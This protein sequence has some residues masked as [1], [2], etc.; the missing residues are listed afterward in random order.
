MEE[1]KQASRKKPVQKADQPMQAF[2]V[3]GEGAD[4][5]IA[6]RCAKDIPEWADKSDRVKAD[7]VRLMRLF[8]ELPPT[9]LLEV[10]QDCEGNTKIGP[11]EGACVTLAVLRT[12][13]TFASNSQDFTNEKLEEIWRYLERSKGRIPTTQEMMSALA[14]VRGANPDDTVQSSLAL[15]MYATHSAAMRA[16]SRME[17]AEYVD[18]VKLF[19]T[20]GTKLLNA[21]TR[22]AETL[23][24]LQRGGEQVIKHIHIDNRGGQ[25]VVTD[26]LIAG[27]QKPNV[28]GQPHGTGSP[29]QCPALPGPDAEGDVVPIPVDQGQEAV[30]AAWG[31]VAGRA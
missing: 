9:P 5:E 25:A 15:Q 18:Q 21:Y 29:A 30:Q 12:V 11:E 13:E 20:L 14:F 26:Q 16:L 7:M 19:G 3:S 10:S 6:A 24:K 28:E 23:A 22:Q 8:W 27:G 4:E 2:I 17:K 31:T 1:K